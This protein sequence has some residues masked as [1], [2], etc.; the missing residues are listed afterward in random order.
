[1]DTSQLLDVFG[2]PTAK[3]GTATVPGAA[4]DDLLAL[5]GTDALPGGGAKRSTKQQPK[6]GL[7][8]VLA[9]MGDMW[10]EAQYSNEFS[11]EAFRAKLATGGAQAGNGDA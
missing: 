5:Q 2:A 1:M 7:A 4:N 11:M 9:G 6:S 10:D 3:P 8:S